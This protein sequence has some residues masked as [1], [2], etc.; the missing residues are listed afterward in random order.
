MKVFLLMII[1][2]MVINYTDD[3]ANVGL[4]TLQWASRDREAT[5]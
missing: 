5:V 3:D 4:E 2:M 1:I